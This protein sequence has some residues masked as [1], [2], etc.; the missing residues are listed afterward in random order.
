M[1]FIAR[2]CYLPLSCFEAPLREVVSAT[3][4]V[5]HTHRSLYKRWEAQL[6]PQWAFDV[7]PPAGGAHFERAVFFRSGVHPAG[8]ALLS[9]YQDGWMTL[10]N[11]L[12][13]L[14]KCDCIRIVASRHVEWGLNAFAVFK[15]GTPIREVQVLHDD[16]GWRHDEQGTPLG[17]EDPRRYRARLRR[18]RLT[19]DILA[20]YGEKLGWPFTHDEFWI[21]DCPAYYLAR[22]RW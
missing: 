13:D 20:E 2:C 15:A 5:L 10:V 4:Q 14:M 11:C 8:T 6:D 22:T 7:A 3:Q 17:F 21:S 12:A 19:W 9:N 16:D 1:S 18:E